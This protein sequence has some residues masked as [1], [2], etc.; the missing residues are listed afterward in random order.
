MTSL[1]LT[2]IKGLA[3]H[4]PLLGPAGLGTPHQGQE[5]T[6]PEECTVHP[7]GEIGLAG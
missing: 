7:R 1:G 3:H 6:R 4:A 2:L 5:D